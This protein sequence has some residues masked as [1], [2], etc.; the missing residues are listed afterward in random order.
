LFTIAAEFN[1][2]DWDTRFKIVQGTCEGVRYIH[3]ELQ[4]PIYHLDL[5]P[6]NILLDK[7]M[8]PKIADFGLSR[9]FHEEP[10]RITNRP[11]GTP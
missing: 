8:V 10:T 6:E 4:A 3:E 7:D 11:Y 1:G 9:I 5:K 2:L